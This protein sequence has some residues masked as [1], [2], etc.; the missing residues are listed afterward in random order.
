MLEGIPRAKKRLEP[1]ID[2]LGGKPHFTWLL[3]ADA[4][5]EK[6]Y[7][8][9]NRI[10]NQNRDFLLNLENDG[11]ELGWHPH[12]W[13]FDESQGLWRQ[14]F[15]DESWQLNMLERAYA[16]YQAVLPGRGKVVRMGWTYHN[17]KTMA[18]LSELEVSVDLSAI[19]GLKIEPKI[20]RRLANFFDWGITPQRPYFPSVEDYRRPKMSGEDQLTILEVPNYVANSLLWGIFSAI[21]LTKK[22]RDFDQIRNAVSARTYMSTITGKPLLFKPMLKQLKRDLEINDKVTYVSP[23]HADEL[24]GNIHPVYSLENLEQNLTSIL[25]LCQRIHARVEYVTASQAERITV[26]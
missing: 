17:N 1:L 16:S 12:F 25:R 22:M 6:I 11:D 19:P 20:G 8:D 4:Q 3:R 14:N 18:K 21:V 24:I 23:M 13:Y 10:L 26:Y 15:Y 7:G 5:I 9:H 2:S